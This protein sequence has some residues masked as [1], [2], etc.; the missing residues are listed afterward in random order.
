MKKFKLILPAVAFIFAIGGAF[1]TTSAVSTIY[2]TVSGVCKAASCDNPNQSAPLCSNSVI[3][4][5]ADC[6]GSPLQFTPG[7][8]RIINP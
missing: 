6:T 5:T 8:L 4:A 2:T 3:Y 1:A 7:R